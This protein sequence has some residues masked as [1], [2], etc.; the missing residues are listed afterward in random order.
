MC[1]N[2]V[3]STFLRAM[4]DL[5]L[6]DAVLL[7]MDDDLAGADG[8]PDYQRLFVDEGGFDGRQLI[9]CGQAGGHQHLPG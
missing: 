4:E 2:V 5:G 3:I 1:V 9:R 6:W 7:S 8:A